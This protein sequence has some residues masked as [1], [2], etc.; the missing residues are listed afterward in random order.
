MIEKSTFLQDT[1]IKCSTSKKL[2]CR[3]KK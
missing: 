2:S 1:D 3:S